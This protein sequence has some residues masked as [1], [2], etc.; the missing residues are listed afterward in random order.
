MLLFLLF[1]A[2]LVAACFRVERGAGTLEVGGQDGVFRGIAVF[3]GSVRRGI[4][5]FCGGAR[6]MLRFELV[7]LRGRFG[8]F[9]FL[10]FFFFQTFCLC[11][12]GLAL[13]HS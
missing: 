2:G 13:E 1:A 6:G 4:G 3:G 9:G 10:S 7:L 11:V 5:A 12:I 8:L